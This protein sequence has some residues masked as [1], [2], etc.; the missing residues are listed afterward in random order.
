MKKILSLLLCAAV[1]AGTITCF[2]A[3]AAETDNKALTKHTNREHLC[4]HNILKYRTEFHPHYNVYACSVCGKEWTD[5]FSSNYSKT[6]SECAKSGETGGTGIDGENSEYPDLAFGDAN[7]DGI[8]SISDVTAVQ[9]HIADITSINESLLNSADFNSDGLINIL[10]A[11][12]LQCYIAGCDME[13]PGINQK[14]EVIYNDYI[15]NKKINSKSFDTNDIDCVFF[16]STSSEFKTGLPA[17]TEDDCNTVY[18]LEIKFENVNTDK[19]KAVEFFEVR[20]GNTSPVVN[21]PEDWT[22]KSNPGGTT[23][24]RDYRPGSESATAFFMRLRCKTGFQKVK[25]KITAN[26]PD[27]YSKLPDYCRREVERV[28]NKVLDTANDSDVV[29]GLFT[30]LHFG[31]QGI[32]PEDDAQKW[33]AVRSMRKVAEEAG[34]DFVIQGGDLLTYGLYGNDVY[35]LN[36]TQQIFDGSSVPLFTS[37][38]DH[39]SAQNDDNKITKSDFD[40]RTTP[41]MP[42]AVRCR[43][44]PSN[45]Y[46]DIAEKKTRVINIDTGTVMSGQYDR[47]EEFRT[48]DNYILF[49]WL[50]DEVFTDEV[51]DGWRFV[52]YTHAPCDY[53]WQFGMTKRFRAKHPKD[54]TNS[55]NNAKGNMLIINDLF[56]AINN[57]GSFTIDKDYN[58]YELE[59]DNKGI[60]TS[61][62]LTDKEMG[63]NVFG[64]SGINRKMVDSP[65]YTRTRDFS[66]WTSKAKIILSGHCHCD[67][68]NTTTLVPDGDNY[69]RGKTSYAI[70]YTGA[71]AK[72]GFK[73]KI[74]PAKNGK[75]YYNYCFGNDASD[76]DPAEGADN[77]SWSH[78]QKRKY[79]DI[80]EQ[81]MDIWIVG[82]TYVKRVR[83]GAGADSP[84]LSTE[85]EL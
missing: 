27:K 72:A 9:Q 83:F 70:A 2:S 17:L 77:V 4:N 23:I 58:R 62:K 73:N 10:D 43:D 54:M 81:L 7:G 57:S 3:S 41:Y 22:I 14:N 50:L 60:L 80:S 71:A 30:D 64:M 74:E 65:K 19:E 15:I 66:G 8:V 39:D 46:F 49:D 26:Q 24:K 13:L 48:W 12:L 20:S 33:Y 29:F 40:N 67:R 78:I 25:V 56:T 69:V 45:Y 34:L 55:Q 84:L 31:D 16:G 6:C 61:A 42:T 37:K 63:G 1:I 52:L 36:K 79:G 28:K 76:T 51:K 18:H 44:F 59:Y 85:V 38:G 75:K 5:Y 21:Y 53:E 68:L 47:G 11:S 32:I 82:D 35:T